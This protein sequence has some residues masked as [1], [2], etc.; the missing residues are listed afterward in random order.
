MGVVIRETPWV[1]R[2]R[3]RV[4]MAE[5]NISNKELAERSKVHR[6]TISN[7]KQADTISQITGDVL[8]KLCNGLTEAY[9]ARGEDAIITPGHLLEFTP[10][11]PEK[12]PEAI[13]S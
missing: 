13:S 4:L 12:P 5:K 7:L 11:E 3:L 1:I 2:W 9:R 10:D 8:N 6:V